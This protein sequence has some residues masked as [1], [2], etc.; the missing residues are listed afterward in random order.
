MTQNY[1][2]FAFYVIFRLVPAGR[3]TTPMNY[4]YLG[5]GHPNS[6]ETMSESGA[7]RQKYNKGSDTVYHLVGPLGT[8]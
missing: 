1:V 2:I 4:I 3:G 5:F 6:Q 8:A 7:G